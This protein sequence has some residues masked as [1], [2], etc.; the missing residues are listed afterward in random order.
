MVDDTQRGPR[1]RRR[2]PF[3]RPASRPRPRFRQPALVH[4]K[5]RGGGGRRRR[6]G[7][8]ERVR[9]TIPSLAVV[10]ARVGDEP[11]GTR[12][13]LRRLTIFAT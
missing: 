1:G 11:S 9:A 7:R 5:R 13:R 10:E 6:R 3:G 12:L 8:G 2:P 4:D